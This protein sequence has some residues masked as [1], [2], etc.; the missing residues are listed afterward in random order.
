MFKYLRGQR[1]QS[2]VEFAVM[3][4][5]MFIVMIGSMEMA[6]GFKS[7][8]TVVASARDAARAGA[9]L[10]NAD[11]C[12]IVM[13]ESVLLTGKKDITIT[14]TTN[15]ASSNQSVDTRRVAANTTTCSCVDGIV[16]GT[17]S[18]HKVVTAT[19]DRYLQVELVYTH[20]LLL[21]FSIPILPST[22]AMGTTARFPVPV[23]Q[24]GFALTGSC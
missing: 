6:W 11:L 22:W 23:Y 13:A 7:Y 17:S 5:I 1:G 8:I 18:G 24:T 10:S 16:T 20:G 15:D 4:P 12:S 3:L 2:L 9:G 14:H 19:A 21:G